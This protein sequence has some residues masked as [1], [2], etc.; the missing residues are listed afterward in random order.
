[1][2]ALVQRVQSCDVKVG[3]EMIGSTGHGIL[4]FLGVGKWDTEKEVDYLAG[5]ITDLRIFEDQEGRM[6]LSLKDIGGEAMVVSQFTLMADTSG[7]NRPGFAKAAPP[8]LA[9][10]LYEAFIDRIQSMGVR[11]QSGRFGAGM[12]VELVN[13]GPVT[14]L[15]ESK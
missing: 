5:K 14:I 15:L 13:D 8:E 6:N 9:E 4:V 7:G 2:K 12:K 11:V 10:P 1:L 3:G